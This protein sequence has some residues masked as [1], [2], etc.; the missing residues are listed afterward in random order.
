MLDNVTLTTLTLILLLL[1]IDIKI[2]KYK[3]KRKHLV[4]NKQ[5]ITKPEP[6]AS[7]EVLHQEK[8]ETQQEAQ[9]KPLVAQVATTGG[10]SSQSSIESSKEPEEISDQTL[11]FNE[12]SNEENFVQDQENQDNLELI[13]RINQISNRILEILEEFEKRGYDITDENLPEDL[14]KLKEEYL[15][16]KEEEDELFKRLIG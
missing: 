15:K 14:K 13:E 7:Q 16:L 9:S 8:I 11:N 4:A 2:R 3:K 5:A 12:A 6:K 1:Y 10:S